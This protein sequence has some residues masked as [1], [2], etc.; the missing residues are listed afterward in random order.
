MFGTRAFLSQ[1]PPCLP[2]FIFYDPCKCQA[3][4]NAYHS[5]DILWNAP[6]KGDSCI[7]CEN[8]KTAAEGVGVRRAFSAKTF[9]K[10]PAEAGRFCSTSSTARITPHS[11]DSGLGLFPSSLSPGWCNHTV[12]SN[13]FNHLSFTWRCMQH[14]ACTMTALGNFIP[15]CEMLA[16]VQW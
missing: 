11:A 8:V 13:H 2:M 16:I 10:A 3:K 4:P 9:P 7:L 12:L 1:F 14:R 5:Q 6:P 15:G